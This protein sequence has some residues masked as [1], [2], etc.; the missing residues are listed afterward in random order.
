MEGIEYLY[1]LCEALPR[2]GPGDNEFTRRAFD[3]IPRLPKQPLILDIGCGPGVQTIE[4][5]KI[6]N[7]SI[8]ALD[9]H[10]AFLDKLMETAAKEGLAENITPKNI[11]MLE[12]DFMEKTFDLIWSEGALYIMGFQNGLK[13]CRRLL[14]NNGYLAVTELVYIATD[15]P[16]PVTEYFENEYSDIKSVK[17]KIDVIQREGFNLIS[18][19]TLPES[20]WFNCYYMQVEKELPRLNEKYKGNEIAL[21][22]FKAF[23]DEID[24]YKKYSD[25]YGYEF[26]IMQKD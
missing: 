2:C 13:E 16:T 26:F 5:A 11:S 20:A 22:V 6:S 8:I 12:M 14:K 24:F 17:G 15:P 19:F 25:F 3:S 18:N 7:G 4:L 1:E 21:A 23:Q 9:N 10:Q